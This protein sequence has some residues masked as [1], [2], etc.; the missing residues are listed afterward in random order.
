MAENEAYTD[1]G[2]F[3][4][5]DKK[6]R[7]SITEKM[8]DMC[9]VSR[10][11]V[12]NQVMLSSPTATKEAYFS[13]MHANA[14]LT[15]ENGKKRLDL[16]KQE[17]KARVEEVVLKKK[18]LHLDKLELEQMRSQLPKKM[19]GAALKNPVSKAKSAVEKDSVE[20]SKA[21]YIAFN[22]KVASKGNEV[23]P[24]DWI[25]F[26]QNTLLCGQICSPCSMSF[27][28]NS[29]LVAKSVV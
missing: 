2:R 23:L 27:V 15:A 20:P 10:Q 11:L 29:T 5:M 17:V 24:R 12:D 14:M 1:G 13:T 28:L 9:A 18:K 19:K 3:I 4:S 25:F 16:E 21:N 8:E 7:T 26:L 22:A 6:R